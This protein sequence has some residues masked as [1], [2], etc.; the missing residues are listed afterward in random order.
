LSDRIA[1]ESWS[2]IP[3]GQLATIDQSW[4]KLTIQ[5]MAEIKADVREMQARGNYGDGELTKPH[6][7]AKLTDRLLVRW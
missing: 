7:S 1:N 2:Q 6:F 3:E 4:T 5:L